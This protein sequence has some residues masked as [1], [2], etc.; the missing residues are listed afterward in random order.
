MLRMAYQAYH[1]EQSMSKLQP[2]V[3][4][5]PEI[6]QNSVR[7]CKA[8]LSD[9]LHAWRMLETWSEALLCQSSALLD[10]EP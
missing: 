4:G 1:Q 2:I 8:K 10:L 6:Q 9:F 3:K 7:Q 5:S